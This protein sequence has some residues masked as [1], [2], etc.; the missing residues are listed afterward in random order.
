[1]TDDATGAPP[2]AVIVSGGSRGLGSSIVGALLDNGHAVGTFSRRDSDALRRWQGHSR[3]YWQSVDAT[4][5]QAVSA[6][7]KATEQRF[8]RISGLVNNAAMGVDGILTTMSVADIDRAVDTNVKAQI[9]LTKLAAARMLKHRDGCIVNVSSVNAIRGH[10]GVAVYSAT[11]G[12]L[13]A[14]TR[15]LARELG[16]RGIRV[17]SVAPGYFASDMVRDL[18]EETVS[19]IARRTPLGRLCTEADIVTLVLFLICQGTFITGQTIAV[20]GGFT[21]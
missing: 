18:G 20:D 15:S 3:F 17:N 2:G 9:Y 21:C 10:A 11:K 13:D 8:G 19:R 12:A 1:V 5:Y 16:P 14:M 6:F 7:V 4:D